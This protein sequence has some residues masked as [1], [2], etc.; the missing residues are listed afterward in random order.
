MYSI[1]YSISILELKGDTVSNSSDP[2][3]VSDASPASI[4]YVDLNSLGLCQ[5]RGVW[6]RF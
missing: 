2:T 5:H 1:V 6:F 3:P 4:R